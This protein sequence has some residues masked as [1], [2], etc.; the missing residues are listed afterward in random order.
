MNKKNTASV[1]PLPETTGIIVKKSGFLKGQL[2]IFAKMP[3]KKNQRLF[4]VKG[5]VRSKPS[6]YSFSAGLH[7]HIEPRKK[8]GDFD[9][10]HYMNHSCNPNT[11]L[12]IIRGRSKIPSIKVI[13]RK[14][15]RKNEE[16]TFDYASLEY[17]TVASSI[18]KCH[19]KNCRK[20]IHGFRDLPEQI[21]KKYQREG[22]IPKYLLELKNQIDPTK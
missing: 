19:T 1:F 15:I 20:T 3:F 5:L 11:I 13:A 6:V 12:K 16:L 10:G 18:C 22:M 8:T 2:G 17:A 7:E 14:N 9:L 21:V 4:L